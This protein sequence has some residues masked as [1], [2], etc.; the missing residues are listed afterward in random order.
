MSKNSAYTVY[1]E[2]T[3]TSQSLSGNTSVV[4]W[5]AYVTKASGTGYYNGTVNNKVT[6]IIGGSTKVDTNISFDFRNA[7]PKTIQL[8]SGTHT[9]THGTTGTGSCTGSAYFND[10]AG[11]L[12]NATASGTLTLTAFDRRGYISAIGSPFQINSGFSITPN[13]RS[14]GVTY[15]LEFWN[16]ANN[17]GIG[18]TAK[19]TA[20]NSTARTI[21]F[22]EAEQATLYNYLTAASGTN[23]TVRLVSYV[24]TTQV[25]NVSAVTT[26]KP[27][28]P[29]YT[30]PSSFNLGDNVTCTITKQSTALKYQGGFVING[31]W[32][33]GQPNTMSAANVTSYTLNG[34]YDAFYKAVMAINPANTSWTIQVY[35]RHYNASNVELGLTTKNITVNQ[36]AISISATNL[37]PKFTRAHITP[38]VTGNVTAIDEMSYSF[39]QGSSWTTVAY[40]AL[41]TPTLSAGTQYKIRFR[42]KQAGSNYRYT[43]GDYTFTTYSAPT[44]SISPTSILL[45][46]SVTLAT[47]MAAHS[48][49]ETVTH[50]L[51]LIR[52]ADNTQV[53]INNSY[54]LGSSSRQITSADVGT[55]LDTNPTLTFRYTLE[56][57]INT[58]VEY[59][60]SIDFVVGPDGGAVYV[61]ANNAW[62]K[63]DPQTLVSGTYTKTTPH[64]LVD[65]TWVKT[66]V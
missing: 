66:K 10:G 3:Q 41:I 2:M 23:I 14:T 61:M 33:T 52:L 65:G 27:N 4:T 19:D 37:W 11:N 54:T 53:G 48:N 38:A 9:V 30:I 6:I 55:L 35:L 13:H 51:K 8:G 15:K 40:G 18:I 5:K 26:A 63:Y 36:P 12:G 32:I 43:S 22:T 45:N 20:A 60:R 21:T 42:F 7:T 1:L 29:V 56:S 59:T 50:R 44:M 31:S 16:A 34:K 58:V 57:I 46:Q 28:A 25:G 24:G 49:Q 39:N 17:A 62:V 64:V 47:A